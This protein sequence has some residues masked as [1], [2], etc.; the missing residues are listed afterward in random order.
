[1]VL[2]IFLTFVYP[3]KITLDTYTRWAG[4]KKVKGLSTDKNITGKIMEESRNKLHIVVRHRVAVTP[5]VLVWN[6]QVLQHMIIMKEGFL[7]KKISSVLC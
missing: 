4:P 7:M 5:V 6:S 1:M 3:R 2:L